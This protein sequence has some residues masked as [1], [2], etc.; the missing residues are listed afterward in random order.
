M[1]YYSE[2]RSA[3]QELLFKIVNRVVPES[4]D[5]LIPFLAQSLTPEASHQEFKGAHYILS[6]EKYGF[7][8]SWK[9][10]SILFPALVQAQ[11]SDKTSIVELLK[12]FSIK[13]NRSYSDFSLYR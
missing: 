10:A 4:Q 2:V 12:D 11:H 8:Y 13:C 3:A 5:R 9:Y 7:F 6:M 1:H